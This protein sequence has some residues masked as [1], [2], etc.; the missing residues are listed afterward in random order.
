MWYVILLWREDGQLRPSMRAMQRPNLQEAVDAATRL[1]RM[2]RR[3]GVPSNLKYDH[4]TV[5]STH[6]PQEQPA[7]A[8]GHFDGRIGYWN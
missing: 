4:W 3:G 5:T 2:S 8:S 1:L 7:N 6:A